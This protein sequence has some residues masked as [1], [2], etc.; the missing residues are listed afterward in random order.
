MARREGRGRD[1]MQLPSLSVFVGSSSSWKPAQP[2]VSERD[3]HGE[4]E[5]GGGGGGGGPERR[6]ERSEEMGKEEITK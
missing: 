4:S 2:N 5:G 6:E 3:K 1:C